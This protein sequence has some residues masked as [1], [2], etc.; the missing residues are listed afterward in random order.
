MTR[1]AISPDFDPRIAEWLE[2][3]PDQAPAPVLDTVLAAFPSI[4]QRRAPRVPWRFNTMT[5]S[6]RVVVAVVVGV[7]IIGVAFYVLRPGGTNLGSAAG[8]SPTPAPMPTALVTSGPTPTVSP[9]PSPSPTATPTPTPLPSFTVKKGPAGYDQVHISDVY[10][11]GLRYPSTWTLQEGGLVNEEDAIPEVGI[12]RNDFYSQG[13]SGVYVTAG[14]VS[15]TRP[16]LATFSAFIAAQ[17][18]ADYTQYT[19]AGCTQPTRTLTLGGE[20]AVEHDF[21]CPQHTALW[22]VAIHDGLAYQ[23]AWLDDGPFKVSDLRPKLDKFLQS[24]TFAP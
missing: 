6:A 13:N 12:G 14:P 23:V 4:P 16:D 7:L 10:R 5:L 18:P 22:V 3:D 8:Q 24:F 11:Y 15:T 19:G 1:H 20:P 21:I 9:A 17:F 2:E